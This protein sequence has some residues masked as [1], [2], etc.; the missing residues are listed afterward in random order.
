MTC[1]G[2][3]VR[4]KAANSSYAARASGARVSITLGLRQST[5]ARTG[6]FRARSTAS[7][8]SPTNSASRRTLDEQTVLGSRGAWNLE[9]A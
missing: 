4:A 3:I 8:C 1:S 6:S 7:V 5:L 2:V 9:G